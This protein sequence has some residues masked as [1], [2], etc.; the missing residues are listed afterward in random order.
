MAGK[1][2]KE[3]DFQDQRFLV[4][5]TTAV[6][7]VAATT[8]FGDLSQAQTEVALG[9]AEGMSARDLAE[10]RCTSVHTIRNQ[11][12]TIYRTLGVNSRPELL[13]LLR[14]GAS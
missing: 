9:W 6:A 10:R 1:V 8:A 5:G 2:A 12:A 3:F 4:I 13:S 7:A 14:G 11:V